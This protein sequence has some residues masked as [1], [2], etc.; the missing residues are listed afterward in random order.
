MDDMGDDMMNDMRNEMIYIN[1]NM[2]KN[3]QSIRSSVNKLANIL[4]GIKYATDKAKQVKD[5]KNQADSIVKII[6]TATN[7]RLVGRRK[8]C[9]MMMR[10]NLH[11]QL[12]KRNLT[13]DELIKLIM[14]LQPSYGSSNLIR[15]LTPPSRT[16]ASSVAQ[17]VAPTVAPTV[18]LSVA[19]STP[20]LPTSGSKSSSGGNRKSR[21]IS[22]KLRNI[23]KRRYSSDRK[24]E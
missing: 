2:D 7:R 4:Q 24:N 12:E 17:T 21:R 3:H 23:T 6:T 14:E 8:T 1:T 16:L 22:R 9:L 15:F 11:R 20:Q 10:N 5:A 13:E 18:A 19:S